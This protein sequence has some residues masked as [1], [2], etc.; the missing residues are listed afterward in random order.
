MVSFI[1]PWKRA[2]AIIPEVTSSNTSK[3]IAWAEL[4]RKFQSWAQDLNGKALQK[5]KLQLYLQYD[6]EAL[7]AISA[8]ARRSAPSSAMRLATSSPGTR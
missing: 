7:V 4:G 2:R 3:Q 6:E 5:F 8:V 1:A